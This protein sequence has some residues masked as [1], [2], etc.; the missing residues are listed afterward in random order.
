MNRNITHFN[1]GNGNCSIIETED[2]L[3]IIDLNKTEESESSYEMLKPH[4]RTKD[5]KDYINVL[6][7]TH[8]DEDHCLGFAKFKE[9]I[10][11]GN[12]V[13]GTIWHQGFDRTKNHNKDTD[14]EL[15]NDY[16]EFQKEIDRRVNIDD[17]I[18]GDIQIPLKAKDDEETAFSGIDLPEDFYLKVLSPSEEDDED[19]G[20]THNDLSLVLKFVISDKSILYTGDSSSKYWTERIIPDLLDEDGYED[21]AEAEIL[22]VGHHG[23]Y[24]FFGDNRDDV[25]E[26]DDEPD[27][28][29]ALDRINPSDLIISSKSKFPLNGDSSGDAPPHYAAWKWYHKWFRN[30]HSVKEKDKHPKEFKYTCDGHV[31]LEFNGNLWV[32]KQ[33]W[34]S[35]DEK[36]RQGKRI[37]DKMKNGGA[38]IGIDLDIDQTEFFGYVI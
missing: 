21:W 27:N 25:R 12:L 6:C 10:D 17:P 28:Y 16:L 32:W 38:V 37:A 29:G 7:I 19:S 22:E 8:G 4:F 14:S 30:N 18:S 31:R 26:S 15:P 33:N 1:V 20:Y 34:K 5:G 9:E 13:I 24:D 36:K 23:S 35:P 2:C 3:V 11:D